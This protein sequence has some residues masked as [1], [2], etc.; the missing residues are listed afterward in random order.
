MKNTDENLRTTDK[1]NA[2]L[3]PI[4]DEPGSHP[5]GTALGGLSGSVA[6]SA[7]GAIGG[8]TG[9]LAGGILGAIAGAVCGHKASE[10]V[11][12]SYGYLLGF[13]VYCQPSDTEALITGTASALEGNQARGMR[14]ERLKKNDANPTGVVKALW[15][16]NDAHVAYVGI[17][18][19]GDDSNPSIVPA[20]IVAV[21]IAEEHIVVGVSR[22]MLDQAPSCDPD[23]TIKMEQERMVLDYYLDIPW[24]LIADSSDANERPQSPPARSAWVTGEEDG[25]KPIRAYEGPRYDEATADPELAAYQ[26]LRYASVGYLA[27]V[28]TEDYGPLSRAQKKDKSKHE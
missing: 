6:G 17:T 20:D 10:A 3:D 21:S 15:L 22:E 8:P 11:R 9:I 28:P 4:T 25:L 1:Y 13:E 19:H 26:P 27:P 2:N 12:P 18:M 5:G 7:I 23:A 16:A 14:I 24:I